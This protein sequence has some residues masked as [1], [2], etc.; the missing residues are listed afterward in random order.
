MTG[1]ITT[2]GFIT[3]DVA[4]PLNLKD[5]VAPLDDRDTG[6]ESAK[7][8]VA[9][10]GKPVRLYRVAIDQMPDSPSITVRIQSIEEVSMVTQVTE[11]KE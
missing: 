3:R 11:V 9:L 7:N 1:M 6:I 10:N 5:L 2:Y 8:K 4:E